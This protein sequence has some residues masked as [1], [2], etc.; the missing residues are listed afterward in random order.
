MVCNRDRK[1]IFKIFLYLI[2]SI[3]ISLNL[4][5]YFT[6]SHDSPIIGECWYGELCTIS[7]NIGKPK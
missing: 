3:M 2:L 7:L 5:L 4:A 6:P 1:K